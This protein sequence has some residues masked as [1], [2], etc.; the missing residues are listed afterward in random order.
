MLGLAEKWK[1]GE[2]IDWHHATFTRRLSP[3]TLRKAFTLPAEVAV[4]GGDVAALT[5]SLGNML[6]RGI[7]IYRV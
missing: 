4:W 7:D 2:R 5:T 1:K 3:F 6:N